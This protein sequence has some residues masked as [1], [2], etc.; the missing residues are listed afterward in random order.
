[1]IEKII[2]HKKEYR[3]LNQLTTPLNISALFPRMSAHMPRADKP[4]TLP[5]LIKPEEFRGLVSSVMRVI[6]EASLISHVPTAPLTDYLLSEAEK[7]A[8]KVGISSEGIAEAYD[9]AYSKQGE[10]TSKDIQATKG[11]LACL[12]KQDRAYRIFRPDVEDFNNALDGIEDEI[13]GK[14]VTIKP[15]ILPIKYSP[16]SRVAAWMSVLTAD[17]VASAAGSIF[18]V[19]AT[20]IYPDLPP[21]L[22]VVPLFS[23]MGVAVGTHTLS[24]DIVKKVYPNILD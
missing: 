17:V 24:S 19:S 4:L 15:E 12:D 6:P 1:M 21:S 3:G 11:L 18:L 5:A 22:V 9:F 16:V 2:D 20:Y 7:L 10:L 13:K 14:F 8:R 23:V